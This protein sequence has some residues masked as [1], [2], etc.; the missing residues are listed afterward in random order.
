M[1]YQRTQTQDG[2][3]V[4]NKALYDNLQDGV[5]GVFSATGNALELPTDE[6]GIKLVRIVGSTVFDRAVPAPN[7]R[8]YATNTANLTQ[9]KDDCSVTV[10]LS[11]D[12][13]GVKTLVKTFEILTNDPLRSVGEFHDE[14]CKIDGV[15]G[16]LRRVH[17]QVWNP[18]LERVQF[19]TSN[20]GNQIVLAVEKDLM[21]D[22]DKVLMSSFIALGI[23]D[24]DYDDYEDKVRC[25]AYKVGST[26]YICIKD[27]TSNSFFTSLSAAKSY[28]TG[29]FYAV[30]ATPKFEPF[31][32][33]VQK[34]CYSLESYAVKTYLD[35]D[36][37]V[38]TP[39]TVLYGQTRA[40]AIALANYNELGFDL[41]SMSNLY[42]ATIE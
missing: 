7:N 36:D 15:W 25:S 38:P 33:S 31:P 34:L 29:G 17:Y 35:I 9:T 6:G 42:S 10:K 5:D 41:V 37:Q 16:V 27:S 12:V 8:A 18:Y 23:P 30:L 4:M 13:N 26:S 19:S 40:S 20:T 39:A 1:S 22:G 32:A 24:N 28:L 21:N 2:V 14:I 11:K 3:T